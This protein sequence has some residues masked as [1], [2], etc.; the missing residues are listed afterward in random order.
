M[1]PPGASQARVVGSR[2]ATVQAIAA[3]VLGVAAVSA[4]SFWGKCRDG[5]TYLSFRP[6]HHTVEPRPRRTMRGGGSGDPLCAGA[7]HDRFA[8][9]H[10]AGRASLRWYS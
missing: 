1:D 9:Y 4:A 8:S 2:N 6:H 10:I 7:D 5:C 3:A